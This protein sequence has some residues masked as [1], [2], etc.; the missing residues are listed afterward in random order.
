MFDISHNVTAGLKEM[1]WISR[2]LYWIPF[3]QLDTYTNF[4]LEGKKNSNEAQKNDM[5][6]NIIITGREVAFSSRQRAASQK[7]NGREIGGER[8]WKSSWAS[9]RQE[10]IWRA[11]KRPRYLH[12]TVPIPKVKL[13]RRRRKPI[14]MGRR[15]MMSA[16]ALLPSVSTARQPG[17]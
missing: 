12:R 11:R 8:R 14:H 17:Q 4:N 3:Y 1:S 13:W 5:I 9:C 2:D 10:R 7:K 15:Y 6:S 16:R